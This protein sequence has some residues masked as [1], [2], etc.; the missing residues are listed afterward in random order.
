MRYFAQPGKLEIDIA[1]YCEKHALEFSLW[2]YKD[3]FDIEIRF[4]DGEVWEIDAKAYHNA[5][6]LCSLRWHDPDQVLG[7]QEYL[8]LSPSIRT[9]LCLFSSINSSSCFVKGEQPHFL[10]AGSILPGYSTVKTARTAT[11]CGQSCTP[12][13]I[14]VQAPVFGYR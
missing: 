5:L 1:R 13:P 14:P 3:R 2:P 4:S 11:D 10:P 9:P 7:S 8:P 6:S 12:M